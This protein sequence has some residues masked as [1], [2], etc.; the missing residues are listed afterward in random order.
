MTDLFA[1]YNLCGIELRN[2]FVR[3]ATMENM[4]TSE[5]LPT[6]D[7]LELYSALAEGQI[8]L[9]ITSAV[10]P[11][12]NWDL[13]PQSKNLCIDSEDSIAALSRLTNLVH[14]NG[15]KIA[16]QLGS[17]FRIEGDLAAPSQ[18]GINKKG[19]ELSVSE[20]EHI[21]SEYVRA[22]EHS[23]AAGFDAVQI[24]AAHGF[25]LSQFLS[26]A[27]N[28][29]SDAYGGNTQ[30]RARIV[31]EMISD[32]KQQTG[33]K[34]PVM[35]K[36]NVMDF[37]PDGVT[38]KEAANIVKLMTNHGLDAVE[39]SGG[40]IGH[41]MNWLG[42]EKRRDWYEGYLRPYARELKT[43]I[44]IPLIMVGGLRSIDMLKEIITAGEA[45]LVA[46]SRP[47]I[48]EPH[49]IK[50]WHEG[51][52]SSAKCVSCNGC[53]DKFFASEPVQCVNIQTDL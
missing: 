14:N 39:A 1:P 25:P 50:R 17:F 31:C 12:R 33:G 15:G 42:P 16:I 27:Y 26:P 7:L 6:Q 8:G 52:E 53:M 36:M 45:D 13:H 23:L 18:S 51:D 9:I 37:T 11:D 48:Q 46:M 34:L 20:I 40:G 44:D 49:L 4:T 30:N 24:N 35:V 32:I 43:Q 29:R 5:R 22:A 19:R 38:V 3:S 2:R 10:R 21:V 41:D 47:F 28:R